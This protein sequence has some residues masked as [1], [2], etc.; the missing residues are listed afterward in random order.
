[1]LRAIYQHTIN[2]VTARYGFEFSRS[3]LL[4]DIPRKSRILLKSSKQLATRSILRRSS[5]SRRARLLLPVRRL[6]RQ[7]PHNHRSCQPPLRT[8][9]QTARPSLRQGP[10]KARNRRKS[11]NTPRI[12]RMAYKMVLECED[13]HCYM[14]QKSRLRTTKVYTSSSPPQLHKRQAQA[15]YQIC[16]TAW[17]TSQLPLLSLHSLLYT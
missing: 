4:A 5:P 12:S 15:Q 9:H 14:R 2:E 10:S 8:S 17:S 1:M 13:H 3:C 6:V 11:W 7:S 16:D